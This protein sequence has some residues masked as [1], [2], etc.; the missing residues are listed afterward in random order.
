MYAELHTIDRDS[1]R[2]NFLYEPTILSHPK[3]YIDFDFAIFQTVLVRLC[4][5]PCEVR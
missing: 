1:L 3:H 5:V 4:Y 2:Y